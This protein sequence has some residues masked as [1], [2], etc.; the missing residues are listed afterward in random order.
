MFPDEVPRVVPSAIQAQG[1]GLE[2]FAGE[3]A[4]QS[5][6]RVDEEGTGTVCARRIALSEFTA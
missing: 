6:Q 1:A 5:A 3:I 2:R 4:A